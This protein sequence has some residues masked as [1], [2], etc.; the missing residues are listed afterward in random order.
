MLRIEGLNSAYIRGADILRSLDFGLKSGELVAVMGR[1]G[2]GKTTLIKT[3]MGLMPYCSGDI[4]FMGQRILG[5]KSYQISNMGVAYVPQGREIFNDF[6]VEQNLLLGALGK[7]IVFPDFDL[8]YRHFPILGERRKQLAGTMSG[9]QQQQL[10]IARAIIGKPG[11]LLL[12]EPSEGIQPSIVHEI[13]QTLKNISA[14]ESLTILLIEQNLDLVT[15]LAERV[16]FI[17]N[18]RIVESVDVGAVTTDASLV[19]RFMS[20]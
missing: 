2:M 11:L 14:K 1:N 4:S 15:M 8:V 9:G 12:D 10:A 3:I 6:T 13:A 17:E 16:D 20:V 19:S 5:R 18:G 7:M